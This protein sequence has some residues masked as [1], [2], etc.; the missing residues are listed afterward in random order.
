MLE[1]RDRISYECIRPTVQWTW[2][3]LHLSPLLLKSSFYL[4]NQDGTFSP[5]VS[6]QIQ[7]PCP[8]VSSSKSLDIYFCPIH[9]K[10][11]PLETQLPHRW[12]MALRQ[13]ILHLKTGWKVDMITNVNFWLTNSHFFFLSY[14]SQV[15]PI[16][17]CLSFQE[18]TPGSINHLH[19]SCR[20]KQHNYHSALVIHDGH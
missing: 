19:R 17:N 1:N 10:D 11:F 2:V 6:V 15:T 4:E 13:G 14:S 20:L 7:T 12:T 16:F 8:I 18:E 9:C 5:L 3:R